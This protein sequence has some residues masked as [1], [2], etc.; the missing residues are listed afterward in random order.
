MSS[1]CKPPLDSLP[2]L[3]AKH[4]PTDSLPLPLTPHFAAVSQPALIFPVYSSPAALL[5]TTTC[6]TR[7]PLMPAAEA[8]L[9]SS[10]P[11]HN[12]LRMYRMNRRPEEQS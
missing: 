7:G 2:L 1:L 5:H 8:T 9:G 4:I 6:V 3:A 12:S 10:W 11:N